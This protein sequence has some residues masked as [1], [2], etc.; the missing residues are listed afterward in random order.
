MV[1]PL[2]QGLTLTSRPEPGNQLALAQVS[3][4]VRPMSPVPGADLQSGHNRKHPGRTPPYI[5][6][7]SVG[8]W[9]PPTALA[10][11]DSIPMIAWG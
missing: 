11:D 4:M 8:H 7:S 6:S 1:R 2:E 5:I 10:A 3:D 9:I